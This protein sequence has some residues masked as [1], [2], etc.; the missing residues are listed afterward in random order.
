MYKVF[1]SLGIIS[2]LNLYC[3]EH[4]KNETLLNKDEN[5]LTQNNIEN[6]ETKIIS[7]DEFEGTWMNQNDTTKL[8]NIGKD[9]C[10][11]DSYRFETNH[12]KPLMWWGE[13]EQNTENSILLTVLN[14]IAS[15]NYSFKIIDSNKA[16]LNGKETFVKINNDYNFYLIRDDTSRFKRLPLGKEELVDSEWLQFISNLKIA[17]KNKDSIKLS[18]LTTQGNFSLNGDFIKSSEWLFR[19]SSENNWDLIKDALQSGFLSGPGTYQRSTKKLNS[20]TFI[21]EK[22]WFENWKIVGCLTKCK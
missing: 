6:K 3:K 7:E 13:W 12:E 19:I 21:F 22:D 5:N 11:Y 15:R 20:F 10:N 8:I 17:V 9:E 1:L 14:T 2:L 4:K 18:K 16:L